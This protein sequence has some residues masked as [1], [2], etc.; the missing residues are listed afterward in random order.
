MV[1]VSIT[2]RSDVE[3]LA[4]RKAQYLRTF[5]VVVIADALTVSLVPLSSIRPL[6]HS[7]FFDSTSQVFKIVWRIVP[8]SFKIRA[9]SNWG[10]IITSTI[11]LLS[12]NHDYL[13]QNFKSNGGS[14]IITFEHVRYSTKF[15]T[16]TS[17]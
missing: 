14:V 5:L 4:L 16:T 12:M 9:K 13:Y 3:N 15:S 2:P 6:G 7:R 8:Y 10:V 17:R 1:A 11:A